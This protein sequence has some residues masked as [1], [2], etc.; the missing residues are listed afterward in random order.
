ME[1]IIEK[2]NKFL[3]SDSMSNLDE[4]EKNFALFILLE[5]LGFVGNEY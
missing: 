5:F 4:D 2:I 3:S 1:E